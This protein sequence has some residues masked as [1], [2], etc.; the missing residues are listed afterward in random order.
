QDSRFE[1]IGSAFPLLN[2]WFAVSNSVF[3]VPPINITDMNG[4]TTGSALFYNG[5]FT[6]AYA[7][8]FE[9]FYIGGSI[10][11]IYQNIDNM[12]ISSVAM[13]IGIL[14]GMYLYSPF[15]S[16]TR[17]FFIGMSMLNLGTAANNNALPRMLRMGASYKPTRWCDLNIDLTE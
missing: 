11:Y 3:W 2:G 6:T 17:N 13:D 14:K 5:V 4:N 12:F 9:N 10:K 8:D 1:N 15:D 16:P 7:Y